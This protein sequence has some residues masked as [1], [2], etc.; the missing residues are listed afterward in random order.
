LSSKQEIRK[1][2][3]QQRRCLSIAEQHVAG[4]SM[5][6]NLRK[7]P[8]YRSAKRI[9]VYLANDAELPLSAVVA[10][11]WQRK[12]RCYLPVLFGCGGLKMHFAPY[13]QNSVFVDN[14]YN[15]PEPSVSIKRQIKATELD[16]VLMPLVGFD[17]D[18]NRLGMGGGYY[19]RS[20]EFL[21]R[22][23]QWR[24]PCL[25]GVAYDFQE[26]ESLQNDP[27]DI[28]LNGIVTPSRLITF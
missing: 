5:L 11:V 8:S 14:Q 20:F 4:V 10:D 16:L 9:A 25:L 19:D 26:V 6:Q 15:I 22:R 28:P 3:R 13:H 1:Q 27:W 24:K 7:F 17:A 18:G 12:K 2:I 21:K 23:K